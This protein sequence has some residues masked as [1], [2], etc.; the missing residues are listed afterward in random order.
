MYRKGCYRKGGRG[1]EDSNNDEEYYGREEVKGNDILL[2]EGLGGYV[3]R[4]QGD[5]RC[6]RSVRQTED[7]ELQ[8]SRRRR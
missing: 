5:R 8:V 3:W 1:R 6:R 2:K 7:R 4:I